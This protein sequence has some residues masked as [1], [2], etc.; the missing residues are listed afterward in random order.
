MEQG[1]THSGQS[2]QLTPEW[3]DY[4]LVHGPSNTISIR[5][6]RQDTLGPVADDNPGLMGKISNAVFHLT[7]YRLGGK[8]LAD[9]Q[10][11]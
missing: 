1:D 8:T 11:D 9:R 10:R 6:T 7:G 3:V 4:T 5:C 2:G